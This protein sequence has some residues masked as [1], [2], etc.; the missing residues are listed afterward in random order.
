MSVDHE[1]SQYV[2]ISWIERANGIVVLRGCLSAMA[3]GLKPVKI[4]DAGHCL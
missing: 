1:K 3:D 2:V 4:R